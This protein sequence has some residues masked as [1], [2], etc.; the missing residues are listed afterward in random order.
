MYIL[1]FFFFSTKEK[2]N[3]NLVV[4]SLAVKMAF[5]SLQIEIYTVKL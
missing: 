3:E 1:A 2:K 5:Y 4:F